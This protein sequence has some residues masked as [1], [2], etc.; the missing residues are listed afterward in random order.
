MS[1][2]PK[3]LFIDI[4]FINVYKVQVGD[5]DSLKSKTIK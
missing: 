5:T 4:A 1:Q 3:I 2:V